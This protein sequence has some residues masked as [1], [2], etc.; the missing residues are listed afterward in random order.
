ML[1]DEIWLRNAARRMARRMFP[2]DAD[3]LNLDE[4]VHR[5]EDEGYTNFRDVRQGDLEEI[6]TEMIETARVSRK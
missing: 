3:L 1:A 4:V 2:G 5:L 6:I